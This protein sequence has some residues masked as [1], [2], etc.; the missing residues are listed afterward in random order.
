MCPA[1]VV[2]HNAELPS[3]AKLLPEYATESALSKAVRIRVVSRGD[4]HLP[5]PSQM[6]R[7]VPEVPTAGSA[8]WALNR[9]QCTKANDQ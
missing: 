3:Y 2:L 9:D 5:T 8:V 6:L 1:P 7:P 4:V